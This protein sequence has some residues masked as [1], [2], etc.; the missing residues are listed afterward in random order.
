MNGNDQVPWVSNKPAYYELEHSCEPIRFK[1]ETYEWPS[2]DCRNEGIC[3]GGNLIGMNDVSLGDYNW[4]D[5][6]EDDE[7][8]A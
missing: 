1:D 8:E 4:Y 6:V 2:C 5:L 7:S 3:N